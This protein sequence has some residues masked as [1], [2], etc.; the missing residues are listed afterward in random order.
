[1]QVALITGG[2]SGIG[3]AT[4]RL[5]LENGARVIALDRN[6]F[7]YP[8]SE[9]FLPLQCDVTSEQGVKDAVDAGFKKFGKIN[10]LCNIAGVIE[11]KS[12]SPFLTFGV[13]LPSLRTE[14]PHE[15]S[16]EDWHRIININLHGPF[17]VL[18]AVV[19]HMLTNESEEKGVIINT[20]SGASVR[21]SHAGTAYTTSK[22]AV[23]GFTRST[24]WLYRNKGIRCNVVYPGATHTNIVVNSSPANS[25][26]K[27]PK[28]FDEV[29]DPDLKPTLM[30]CPGINQPEDVA[31]AYLFLANAQGANGVEL[32]IDRG[33]LLS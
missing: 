10:I 26:A 25:G 31:V 28:S 11:H 30:C 20:G 5:F 7:T 27:N 29:T 32:P 6:S 13:C 12:M 21:G 14:P 22:H 9:D 15:I 17:Y 18:K 1:L 24:A 16:T 3:L 19:P 8:A 23:L 33:W 2:N 4:V